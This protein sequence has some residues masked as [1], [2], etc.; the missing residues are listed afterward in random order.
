MSSVSPART[1]EA[2]WQ[3][4]LIAQA[5]LVWKWWRIGFTEQR[6]DSV[7]ANIHWLILQQGMGRSPFSLK[8][9]NRKHFS[10]SKDSLKYSFWSLAFAFCLDLKWRLVGFISSVGLKQK[11]FLG[12]SCKCQP[13]SCLLFWLY[14][15]L[16][17][18]FYNFL[19]Y[20]CGGL[21]YLIYFALWL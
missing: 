13:T 16:S 6:K 15:V 18:M 2:R 1:A 3:L 20:G 11:S 17:A 9:M 5:R 10:L 14:E 19:E 12:V 4:Q 8:H 21:L 7:H